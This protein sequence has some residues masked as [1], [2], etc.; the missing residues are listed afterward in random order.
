[1]DVH[2]RTIRLPAEVA[3]RE[4]RLA[5]AHDALVAQGDVAPTIEEIAEAA[6]IGLAEALALDQA[7]RVVTSLDRPVGDNGGTSLGELVAGET[8]VGEEVVLNLERQAVRRA[9]EGLAEPDR[10]IVKRRFGIDGDPRPQSTAA[11]ARALGITGSEVRL[12]EK[13]A[14]AELARMRE[15]E[16]IA[17]SSKGG[18]P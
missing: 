15:L 10:G 17:R 16:G 9:V 7:P 1:M 2:A 12:I 14:L 8:D 3:R 6:G 13:R 5:R 4:R 11:I 18:P